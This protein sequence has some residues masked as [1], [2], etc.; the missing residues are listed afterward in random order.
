MINDIT[1]KF[2]EITIKKFQLLHLEHTRLDRFH[3][4]LIIHIIL[5]LI[6]L[7][8]PFQCPFLGLDVDFSFVT[9]GPDLLTKCIAACKY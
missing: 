7:L 4:A 2:V 6:L 3:P 5:C 1:Q 8:I 9:L